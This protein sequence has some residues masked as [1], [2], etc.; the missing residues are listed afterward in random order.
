MNNFIELHDCKRDG[1][2]K[3]LINVSHIAAVERLGEMSVICLSRPKHEVIIVME[4]YEEVKQLL[5][6][7]EYVYK[8][9]E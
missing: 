1:F 7:V 6:T 2:P 5:A 4:S 8:E 9:E 3:M